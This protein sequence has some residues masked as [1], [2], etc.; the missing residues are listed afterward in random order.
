MMFELP[1]TDEQG[2]PVTYNG[3]PLFMSPLISPDGKIFIDDKDVPMFNPSA[4]PM[5][6]AQG[7]PIIC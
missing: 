3:R 4:I 2:Y 5:I 6:N 1:I 7:Q